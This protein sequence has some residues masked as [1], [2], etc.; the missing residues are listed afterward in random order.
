M[1]SLAVTIELLLSCSA[2]PDVSSVFHSSHLSIPA[3]STHPRS[4]LLQGHLRLSKTFSTD[5]GKRKVQR[6]Q[7]ATEF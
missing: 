5:I 1:S 2:G 3:P 6:L 4:L 7:V